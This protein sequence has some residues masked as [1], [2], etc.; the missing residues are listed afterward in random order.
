LI[1]QNLRNRV[2]GEELDFPLLQ[3]VLKDYSSPRDK[4]TRLLKSGILIRVKKGLYIFSPQWAKRPYSREL[5]A[6]LIYGPSVVSLQSALAYYGLIPERVSQVT[7]ITCSRDKVFDTP[8]GKFTYRYLN[9][10]KYSIGID[11]ISLSD[12]QSFL[13]ACKEKALAD[14]LALGGFQAASVSD[15]EQI[16]LHDLRCDMDLVSKL[17]VK[18]LKAIASRY[19]NRIIYLLVELVRLRRGL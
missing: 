16:L 6:N 12:Q 17:D 3:D 5:L 8:V 4:I 18:L 11:L 13:M 14:T 9:I 7:S 2:V 1:E 10:H 15:L 19:S